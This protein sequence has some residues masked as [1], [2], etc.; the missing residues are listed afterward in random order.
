M[1]NFKYG[2]GFSLLQSNGLGLVDP[3]NPVTAGQVAYIDPSTGMIEPG[4]PASN[5]AVLPGF[6][7]NSSTDTDVLAAGKIGIIYLDGNTVIETD[8]T[9]SAISETNYPDG[10]ALHTNALGQVTTSTSYST[11]VIGYA[12][13]NRQLPGR[14]VVIN[15]VNAQGPITVLAIKLT[16]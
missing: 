13:G 11:K 16:A 2:T 7:F 9:D 8:Q 12:A 5:A 6:A 10:T 1:I 15:G 3:E 4:V 14:A